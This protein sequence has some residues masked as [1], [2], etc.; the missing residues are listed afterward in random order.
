ME[1]LE[2]AQELERRGAD[3]AHLEVGEPD[4]DMPAA[5]K[6]AVDRAARQG[7]THYTHSLGVRELREAIAARYAR[8]YGLEVDP[9]RV[10]V[11]S[12]S[13]GGLALVMALLLDPGDEVLIPDPGY[14][15]Y[16]NFVRMFHGR[17][18]PFRLDP[19]SGFACEPAAVR[20]AVGPRSRLLVVNSPANPTAAVQTLDTLRE[21]AGLGIPV[22][23]DEIYH[24]LEYGPRAAS[25]LEVTGECFVI[26]GFSKRWAMTGLRLGWLVAPERFVPPLQRLQQNLFICASSVAQQAGIAAIERCEE[27]ARA[28]VEEYRRRREVLVSG[29]KRLGFPIPADPM[30]AYYVLAGA[31]HLGRD[32]LAL[33]KRILFEARVG[34]TPGIDFGAEAEG[35]LRFS[36]A[37]RLDRIEEGLRRLGSWLGQ[38]P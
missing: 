1:I 20:A 37:S 12:G 31:R 7:H 5:V 30:G 2:A 27:D 26:D 14:A 28:M 35:H 36:F 33:A 23:S 8:R 34:V 19:R 16:P 4:F 3:I 10:I 11:T 21:L 25:L 24:G 38:A 15:C 32:S 29:L 17:P 22:L 6:E 9:G 13:S 18:R